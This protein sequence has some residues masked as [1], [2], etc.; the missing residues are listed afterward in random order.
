M[1]RHAAAKSLRRS[2]SAA[3]TRVMVYIVLAVPAFVGPLVHIGMA[4]IVMAV[5]AFVGPLAHIVLACIVMAVPAFVG[6]LAHIVMAVKS[7]RRSSSAATTS[8]LLESFTAMTI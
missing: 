2:S 1:A 8:G 3:T 4:Y 5:P 7:L 6:P